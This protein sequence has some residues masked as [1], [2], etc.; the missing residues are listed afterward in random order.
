MSDLANEKV[1][2]LDWEWCE[3]C[4]RYFLRCPECRNNACNGGYGEV[5]GEPCPICPSVYDLQEEKW[6]LGLYPAETPY[7]IEGDFILGY[8][9][10][11]MAKMW[12]E[13]FL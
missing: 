11:D 12:D 7:P 2:D 8:G 10:N 9:E 5:D 3:V 13:D 4:E 6:K 1:L